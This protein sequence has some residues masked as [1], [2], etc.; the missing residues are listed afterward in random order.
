MK[1]VRLL[2]VLALATVLAASCGGSHDSAAGGGSDAGGGGESIDITAQDFSFDT[3]DIKLDPGQEVT[4]TLTN[5][6]E[7]EH[8]F[9]SEELG[10]EVEAAGGESAETTFTAPDED[11]TFEF[12]CE[13]HPDDMTG[14]ITVGAG[15]GGGG[16]GD[17]PED[18]GGGGGKQY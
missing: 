9:T 15:G 14:T 1:A 18:G 3:T 17:K 7:A 13:Y 12:I 6:G 10:V 11:G 16:G 4:V 8:T 5:E 2:R